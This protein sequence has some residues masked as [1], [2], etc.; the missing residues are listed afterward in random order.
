MTEPQQPEPESR[1]IDL[2]VWDLGAIRTDPFS[3]RLWSAAFLLGSLALVAA[4]IYVQPTRDG[5]GNRLGSHQQLPGLG[6]CGMMVQTGFPCPTCGMTT[7]YAHTVRGQLGQ[8]F[9]AQPTGML[10]AIATILTIPAAGWCLLRGRLPA[11]QI[12]ILTPYRL[13]LGALIL[14]VA[15]WAFKLFAGLASGTLPYRPG[16]GF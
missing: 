4:A 5:A 15:G 10:L 13:C 14:L 3:V 11:V 1:S 8:A 12:P 9:L 7:A 16:G 6:P 2:T